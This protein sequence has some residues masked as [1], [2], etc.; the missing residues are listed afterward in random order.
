MFV[1]LLLWSSLLL[2]LAPLQAQNTYRTYRNARFGTIVQ[3]PANLVVAKPESDNGDGR[4]FVSRDNQI[5]LTIYAFNNVRNRSAEGEMNR[6]IRDWRRDAAR[7]T[8]QKAGSGWFV[9]SGYIGDDIFYEKTLLRGQVF[10][11]LIWQYPKSLRSN[12]DAP[13]TR[14]VRTFTTSAALDTPRKAATP[15][16]R[17]PASAAP[18]TRSTTRQVRSSNKAAPTRGY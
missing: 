5:E 4:K 11:S 6:A 12:L 15:S 9:L 2:V 17:L 1:R 7:L 18:Q 10:H 3:Y 16:P 14:S 8:Y 13:V